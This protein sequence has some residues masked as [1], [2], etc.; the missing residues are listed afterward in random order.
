MMVTIAM[1]TV[2][3]VMEKHVPEKTRAVADA[4]GGKPGQSAADLVEAMNARVGIPPTMRALGYKG[5]DLEE[6]AQDCAK[7]HFLG[8]SPYR[9]SAAEFKTMLV[10]IMG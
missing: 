10:T 6:M 7:S 8:R 4:L 1:P 3:R 5:G 9:P 2:L